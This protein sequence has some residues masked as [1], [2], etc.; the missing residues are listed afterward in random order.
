MRAKANRHA[1]ELTPVFDPIE[2]KMYQTSNA[3]AYPPVRVEF[4]PE[5]DSLVP[6]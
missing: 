6:E 3:L 1:S 4:V 5:F 2:L